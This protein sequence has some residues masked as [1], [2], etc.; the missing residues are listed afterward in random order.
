[1]PADSGIGIPGRSIRTV[2]F[3]TDAGASELLPAK[4]QGMEAISFCVRAKSVSIS[5]D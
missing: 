2:L 1:M 5:L 3:S 4:E